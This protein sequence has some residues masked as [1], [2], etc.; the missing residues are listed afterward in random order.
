MHGRERRCLGEATKKK[1]QIQ[2]KKNRRKK[3][4]TAGEEEEEEEEPAE[5]ANHR[6]HGR[7]E[8]LRR[9]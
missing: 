4:G 6:S 3:K 7:L 9:P 8:L 5:P 2:K 1:N